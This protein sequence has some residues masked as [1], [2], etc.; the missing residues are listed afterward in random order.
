MVQPGCCFKPVEYMLVL[1][2]EMFRI[3]LESIDIKGTFFG[4]QYL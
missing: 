3:S 2:R 1:G 4:Y